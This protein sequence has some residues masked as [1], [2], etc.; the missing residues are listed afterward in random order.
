MA[1]QEHEGHRK[2]LTDK[3]NRMGFEFLEEHEQL[4]MILFVAIPRGDTNKI[5]HNLL[6][7]FGS[8]YN[9][10]TA[11]VTELSKVEGVGTRTAQYLQD[12]YTILGCVERNRLTDGKSVYP[13]VKDVE[14][15]GRYAKSLFFGKL[16]ECFYMVSVNKRFQAF[17][18]DKIS[19]GD[20]N[21]TPIYLQ[22]ILRQALANNAAYV[23]FIHNHPS[24]SLRPSKADI[25]TTVQLKNSFAAVGISVLDHIIVGSGEFVSL[26][27]LGIV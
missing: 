11:R 2:R 1:G 21:E 19:N 18:T 5:A 3:A 12:L 20:L 26:K 23:F 27:E 24:G 13:F 9:V 7:K 14:S 17:K 22:E 16:S 6:D 25:E 4:E 8:L 15:M 10:L